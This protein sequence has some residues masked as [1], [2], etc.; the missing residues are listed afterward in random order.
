MCSVTR[1]AVPC[2]AAAC[3]RSSERYEI[4]QRL[5]ELNEEVGKAT[6][7]IRKALLDAADV[8]GVTCTGVLVRSKGV[9]IRWWPNCT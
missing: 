8:V 6:K 2:C 1:H 5:D 9:L 7:E 4:F 3:P